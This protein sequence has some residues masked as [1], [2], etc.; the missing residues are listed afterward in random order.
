MSNGLDLWV[1]K[2]HA[3]L[4]WSPLR[5]LALGMGLV[6]GGLVMWDPALFAQAIGGFG[7]VVSP[8]LIWS[9]CAAMIFGVGFVPHRW[10]WQLLFTPYLALP[11][12]AAILWLRLS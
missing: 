9:C 11:I 8:A 2:S 10:Y 3:W 4:A 12:L 5:V 6:T 1:K 7:P